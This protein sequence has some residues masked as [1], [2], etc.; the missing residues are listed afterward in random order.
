M[1]QRHDP[2]SASSLHRPRAGR[3]ALAAFALLAML[4][5]GCAGGSATERGPAERGDPASPA[6]RVSKP[7]VV[8]ASGDEP[9]RVYFVLIASGDP[10]RRLVGASSPCCASVELRRTAVVAGQWDSVAMPDGFD[11]PPIGMVAF[12]P[13]TLFL[14]LG[15]AGALAPGESIPI[16]LELD[17]GD[18]LAFDAVVDAE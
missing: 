7:R 14:R 2:T 15:G 13:R 3:P 8:P 10:A 11:L 5:A 17:G 16:E 4:V 6:L 9:P 18:R 1:R 12:A